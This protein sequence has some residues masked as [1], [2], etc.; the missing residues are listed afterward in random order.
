MKSGRL[1]PALTVG[2]GLWVVLVSAAGA[3]LSWLGWWTPYAAWPTALGLAALSTWCVRGIP[4]IR[5]AA[6]ATGALVLVVAAFTVW[7]GAT[8]SEQ[9]LPRRDAASNL[10]AAVSLASTGQRV[11]TIDPASVGGAGVLDDRVTL[12]SPAFYSVGSSRDPAVQPQFVI[13]P[14]VVYSLGWWLG[15]GVGAMLVPVLAMGLALLSLGL[16]TARVV[17]AWWGVVASGLVAV[18][19]PVVHTARATYSEPLAMLTLTGGLLALTLVA[20][21]QRGGGDD[22]APPNV[23]PRLPA[24]GPRADEVVAPEVVARLALVAGVLLGGTG[25]VRVDALREVVLV[26][27]VLALGAALGGRWVRPLAAG[28]GVSLVAAVLAA[29]ALSSRYLG[30]IADSLVPLAALAVLVSGVCGGLLVLFRRG[31]RL[32]A[33]VAGGM[34]DAVAALTILTGLYLASRPLWQVT[35]QDPNDPGARYVAGMQGRE[36]LV[37]DGGRTYAEHTVTWLAWYLGPVALVVALVVLAALLRH[38]VLRLGAGELPAW[39]PALVLAGGS[40]L[41][42]LL[43]PGI[44]PDHPWAD[45]RLLIALPL[46]VVLDVVAAAW[47]GSGLRARGHATA[48]RALAVLLV[49]TVGAPAV[50]AT[51]PHRAGGVE[52]GSLAAARQVCDSLGPRDV[53]LM[54][55]SRSANEWTQ[56]VR[57]MCPV[58]SM[59]ATSA[60]RRDPSALG[61]LVDDVSVAVAASGGRLVLLAADSS[62]SLEG[63]GVAAEPVVDVIVQEDQHVL[64]RRPDGTD[65]LPIRVWLGRPEPTS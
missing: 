63:L 17:G 34:P 1:L 31:H 45:R 13:G 25:F 41:L 62:E 22:S 40:T 54:V 47:L 26:L 3:L 35:R 23:V 43:R 24:P 7:V 19:F 58:P 39:L 33:R 30:D 11:V 20:A 8:H 6:P 60:V 29:T 18:V 36:G 21:A 57:G 61:A 65:P 59:A 12:G 28:L 48:G 27:P 15:G 9:V 49:L 51:W 55:D 16:L 53:V 56:V 2:A 44:T 5:G 37:I 64:E 42:T 14:A 10:Q 4:A 50:V 52:R 46:V 38:A 32:P